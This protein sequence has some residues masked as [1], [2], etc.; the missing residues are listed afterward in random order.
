MLSAVWTLHRLKLQQKCL[1]IVVHCGPHRW[2]YL[3][4]HYDH[5]YAQVVCECVF[6]QG[7]QNLVLFALVGRGM[8]GVGICPPGHGASRR[9]LLGLCV[10]LE[11]SHHCTTMTTTAICYQGGFFLAGRRHILSGSKSFRTWK[12][13]SSVFFQQPY[14]V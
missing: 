10:L 11:M 2:C 14:W 12:E 4:K 7:Q 1:I 5:W 13:V 9:S 3:C 6:P 8:Q